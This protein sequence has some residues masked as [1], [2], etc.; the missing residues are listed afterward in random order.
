MGGLG[1]QCHSWTNKKSE[2]GMGAMCLGYDV[3][4][5]DVE[6]GWV[7]GWLCCVLSD[8]HDEETTT[9]RCIEIKLCFR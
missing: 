6:R 4:G 7:Y 3:Y 8:L 2:F 1:A 5:G 9:M